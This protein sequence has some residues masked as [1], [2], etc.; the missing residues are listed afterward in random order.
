MT[1]AN[2]G[3][4][5]RRRFCKTAITGMTAASAAMV[6]YPV[7]A[8]LGLP[9]RLESNKPLEVPLDLLQE[10]QARYL[11]FRGLQLIL[12]SWSDT[13]NVF[14][15]SCPHLGCNVV[16]ESAEG[17]F[18]CPCHGAVFGPDGTVVSGPVSAPLQ[19]VP[20]EI[21]DGKAIIG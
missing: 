17:T 1:C 13:V 18:R 16:W 14:N 12:L 2:S 6:T 10:G 20:F 21:Q 5:G 11:E 4:C 15:A 3:N 8:F 7:A 19:P 9:E